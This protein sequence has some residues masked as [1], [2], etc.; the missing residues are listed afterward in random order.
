[1][2]DQE[3]SVENHTTFSSPLT[4]SGSPR[5]GVGDETGQT[6]SPWIDLRTEIGP[7]SAKLLPVTNKKAHKIHNRCNAYSSSYPT[8]F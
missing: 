5:A 1:M 4:S 8:V 2:N 3:V 7:F 6:V